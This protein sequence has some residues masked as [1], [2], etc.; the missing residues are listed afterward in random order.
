MYVGEEASR[1]AAG[2]C[3]CAALKKIESVRSQGEGMLHVED[4]ISIPNAAHGY[5]DPDTGKQ[6]GSFM[7]YVIKFNVSPSPCPHGM[8]AHRM[9]RCDGGIRTL[10][11]S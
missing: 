2:E 10:S 7:T 11:C 1:G 4:L 8:T 6:L 5:I 9:V 3:N